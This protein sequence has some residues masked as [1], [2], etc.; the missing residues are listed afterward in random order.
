MTDLASTDAKTRLIVS[1]NNGDCISALSPLQLILIQYD[2]YCIA[3]AL[4]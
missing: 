2:N 4:S 3:L 1:G